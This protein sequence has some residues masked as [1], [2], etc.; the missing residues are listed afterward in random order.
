MDRRVR[1]SILSLLAGAVFAVLPAALHA[2]KPIRMSPLSGVSVGGFSTGAVT[3][4]PYV[5]RG[6]DEAYSN[7]V[8]AIRHGAPDLLKR[9]LEFPTGIFPF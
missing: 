6:T 8:M 1:S 3:N 5:S 4:V 9:T 2:Q 7:I